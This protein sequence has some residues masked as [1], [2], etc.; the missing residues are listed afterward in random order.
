[1]QK[2]TAACFALLFSLPAFSSFTDEVEEHI[3]RIK[4]RMEVYKSD[5]TLLQSVR[6]NWMEQYQMAAVQPCGGNAAPLKRGAGAFDHE[7]RRSWLCADAQWRS[8]THFS[9]IGRVGGL[10]HRYSYTAD[11]AGGTHTRKDY[12]YADIFEIWVRQDIAPVKGLSVKLGK[13]SPLFS[14]DYLTSA[15]ALLCVERSLIGGPQHGLDS[16]WGVE[17]NYAPT[18]RDTLFFQLLANDRASDDKDKHHSDR[19]GDGCGEK[20]E[21]GWEDKCFAVLGGQHRF[22]ESEEGY[23]AISAQYMHDFDNSYGNQRPRGA[24]Y[25]GANVKDALSVGHEWKRGA[26]TLISNVIADFEMNNPAGSGNNNNL[27]WQLQPVYA[28]T[29]HCDMVLRYTGMTGHDACK[30]GADRYIC[31]HTGADKW[32]DSVHALYMGV[33]LYAS[34][35]DKHA[36][37]LMLGAE[38]THAR[39]NGDTAYCGWELTTALRWNF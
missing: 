10:P 14:T 25:Y 9:V 33:N 8:G 30:L 3:A 2:F 1:M 37:K 28:L 27:G 35:R 15:S 11:A 23:Q 36:A 38:Y 7:F 16:N 20:G 19:Y 32:V 5:E 39:N 26:L 24:N 4:E 12:S 6:L 22:A 17:V 13:V 21:F 18:Q 34:A 31:R 29:P